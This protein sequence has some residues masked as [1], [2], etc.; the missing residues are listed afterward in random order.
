MRITVQQFEVAGQLLDAIDVAS[1]FEFDG[2]RVAA[3]VPGQ[4]VDRAD[5]RRVLPPEQPEALSQQFDL[6]SK[7]A[8][9]VGLD[10]V[11]DQS[12]V[13]PQLV[14]GVV[15]DL[16]QRDQQQIGGL[17][18]ADPPQLDHP[19]VGQL[20]IWGVNRQGARRAHPVQRFIAESVAMNKHGTVSF[21]QQEPCSQR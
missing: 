1:S 18:V 14:G 17:G 7:Q 8:L 11:L 15:Q 20:G 12:G 13:Q 21:Q 16:V 10:A 5:R 9:Q 19:G 2:N 6:L 3:G 4:D